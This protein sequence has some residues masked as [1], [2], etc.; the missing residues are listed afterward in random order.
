MK[1][2]LFGWLAMA[3]MLVGTGCSSD[4]VVN[5]YS[6]ENAIQFG[7][8]VG[9]NADGR[10]SIVDINVIGEDGFG[11][12]AYY[13]DQTPWDEYTKKNEPNF[14]NNTKVTK[15]NDKWYYSPLKYWPNNDDA[16]V[17]FFAYAPWQE[18]TSGSQIVLNRT[19]AKLD[20]K[21]ENN[22]KDQVDL[23]WSSSNYVNAKKQTVDGEV[24]FEFKHAL[25]R[26]GFTVQAAVN[27]VAPGGS[28]D[29]H[30]VITLNRIVLGTNTNGFF[31]T[32]T[33][34]LNAVTATWTN[35]EGE[36][37]FELNATNG[38]FIQD[39]NVLTSASNNQVL[40]M[41]KDVDGEDDFLMIIPEEM[42]ELSVYI[43]YTVATNE[44]GKDDSSVIT[45]KITRKIDDINFV[46]GNAYTLNLVLG[47]TSV[48]ISATVEPWYEQ[49][50][51]Q[52]DLPLNLN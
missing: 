30:T 12:F 6:P 26:I 50:G 2:N 46:A 23:I 49:T 14:M 8:Y 13:T 5:D 51:N 10:A 3:T 22:V 19:E 24:K 16:M 41:D 9:K 45:N 28:I 36:Q 38:N 52:V 18:G 20:F 37:S 33:L 43:E 34:D 42:E 44:E 27:Q 29:E 25:S 7:T 31:E 35:Q 21:V 47:M 1:K 17:T 40:L 4:E 15:P 48:N 39:S 32:G 11:V